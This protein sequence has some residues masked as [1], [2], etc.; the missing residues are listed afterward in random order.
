MKLISIFVDRYVNLAGWGLEINPET[1]N[2]EQTDVL[3]IMSLSVNAKED[4]ENIFTEEN[5]KRQGI[6][7]GAVERNLL[8]EKFKKGF[9]NEI[10]CVGHPFDISQGK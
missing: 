2:Y 3:K 8:K 10:A 4:C 7:I 6:R 5:L 1:K 9:T